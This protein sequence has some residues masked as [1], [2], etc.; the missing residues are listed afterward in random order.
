[1]RSASIYEI[2]LYIINISMDICT[3]IIAINKKINTNIEIHMFLL[4][5]TINIMDIKMNIKCTNMNIMIL[6]TNPNPTLFY[7]S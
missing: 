7:N 5:N 1:M 2:T 4:C 3:N 6:A